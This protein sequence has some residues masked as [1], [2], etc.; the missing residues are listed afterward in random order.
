MPFEARPF[1]FGKRV[2]KRESLTSLILALDL[3]KDVNCDLLF[4]ATADQSHVPLHSATA[5]RMASDKAPAII[6]FHTPFSSL[7]LVHS[8][9]IVYLS[10]VSHTSPSHPFASYDRTPNVTLRQAQ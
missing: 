10:Q 4:D 6:S 2:P 8:G 1:L 7:A 5:I 9:V 3:R